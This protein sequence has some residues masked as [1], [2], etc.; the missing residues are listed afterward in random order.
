MEPRR[1][2]VGLLASY[3]KSAS[4][5]PVLA[6]ALAAA[7]ALAGCGG[8]SESET[9]SSARPAQAEGAKTTAQPAQGKGASSAQGKGPTDTTYQD[10]DAGQGAP[11]PAPD[12]EGRERGPTPK[13]EAEATI[14]DIALTSPALT[15]SGALPSQYTC[16][17]KD[18]WPALRWQGVPADTEELILFAMN[19]KPLEGKLFFDWALAGIDPE[20]G[21]IE[22]GRLPRG[23]I[24][25]RNGFGRRGYSICPAQGEA[26]TYVF[27]LFALPERL[28]PPPGFDPRAL[29]L[30]VLEVS[31]N[32]GLMAASYGR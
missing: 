26:E 32:V 20:L 3:A 9:A 1:G 19:S 16:D 7:L 12:A 10:R 31:G 5:G 13:E 27:A 30:E 4:A 29:R 14:A 18:R 11:L 6:L 21:E 25:G 8:G 24:L 2:A 22:A 28:S 15:A 17:G 23:A